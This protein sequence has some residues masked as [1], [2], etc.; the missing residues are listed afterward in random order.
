MPEE[1]AVNGPLRDSTAVDCEIRSVFAG[2]VGVNDL[3]EVLLSDTTL[4]CNEYAEVGDSHLYRYFNVAIEQGT[5]AD[6]P[7]PLLD[8]Q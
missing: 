2:G 6:N 3:R 8:C 4:T 1:F 5:V 7:E